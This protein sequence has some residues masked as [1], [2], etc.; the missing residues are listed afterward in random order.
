MIPDAGVGEGVGVGVDEGAGVDGRGRGDPAL[1]PLQP[2][3]NVVT[4]RRRHKAWANR[5]TVGLLETRM[6]ARTI[7]SFA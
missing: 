6:R 2:S 7:F 4:S 3:P 1:S 5:D